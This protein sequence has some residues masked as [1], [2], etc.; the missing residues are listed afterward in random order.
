MSSLELRFSDHEIS[1][2]AGL[3]LLK[4][5]LDKSGFI[6]HLESLPLPAQGSNRGYDPIQ[7]FIQYGISLVWS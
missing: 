3:G 4:N 1:S 6:H 2:W 7:L 5:I